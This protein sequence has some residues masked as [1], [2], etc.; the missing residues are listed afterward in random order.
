MARVM[1]FEDASNMMLA[2]SDT[3][4]LNQHAAERQA[5]QLRL[6]GD[7][8]KKSGGLLANATLVSGGLNFIQTAT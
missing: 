1:G 8:T 3:N 4:R 2:A 7:F 5:A 6:A